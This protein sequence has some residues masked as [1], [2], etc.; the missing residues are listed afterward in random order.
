MYSQQCPWAGRKYRRA[1]RHSKL[2]PSECSTARLSSG[3]G[4]SSAQPS[5]RRAGRPVPHLP[6]GFTPQKASRRFTSHNP[7]LAARA[8][9]VRAL[10]H[11]NGAKLG[12]TQPPGRGAARRAAAPPVGGT[13]GRECRCLLVW[14][15]AQAG[16]ADGWGF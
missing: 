1:P 14:K 15:R 12:A 6:T 13:P 2:Q 16:S 9:Q 10:A 5:P 8:R 3:H 7:H 4:G 11:R